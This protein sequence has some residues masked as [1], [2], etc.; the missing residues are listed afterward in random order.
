[1]LSYIRHSTKLCASEQCT[2]SD[3]SEKVENKLKEV[4]VLELRKNY[5]VDC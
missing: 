3:H 2:F 5:L 4:V 1:M